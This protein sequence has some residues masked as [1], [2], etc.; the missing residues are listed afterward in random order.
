MLNT[1]RL[2]STDLEITDIGLGTW[3]LGGVYYGP[4]EDEVG[5]ETVRAYLDAGGNH[6]D[7]ALRYH[8]SEELIGKAI[9]GRDRSSFILASKTY[10]SGSVEKCRENLRKDVEISLRDLGTD[11]LDIYYLHGPPSEDDQMQGVLDEYDKLREEGLFKYIGVSIPGPVVTDERVER[12]RKYIASGRVHCLQTNY[13][14]LR[15]KLGEVFE[16]AGKAGVGI[17]ARWV[18]ESGFLS[19]KYKPGHEFVW[20][21]T[22]N[23]FEPE[24]RDMILREIQENICTLELPEGYSTPAQLAVKFVLSDPN[25]SGVILGCN[26]PE[27][28][29]RNTMMS[30]LPPLPEDLVAKLKALYQ[31][32]NDEFNPTGDFE[33]VPS[34]RE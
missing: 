29:E 26:K 7:T 32:R 6:I 27:H 18:L 11:Y 20:P 19:G 2:G 4:V 13:S 25:V 10:S 21:D 9:A 34:P 14:I 24:H 15:Q 30:S 28:V 33:H 31:S 8:K 5:I 22:R 3:G 1:R 17:I 12:A 16:E 23:R